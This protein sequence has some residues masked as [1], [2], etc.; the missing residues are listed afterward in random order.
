MRAR[1]SSTSPQLVSSPD[2]KAEWM[3]SMVASCRRNGRD[4]TLASCMPLDGWVLGYDS[5]VEGSYTLTLPVVGAVF[6][7]SISDC[8]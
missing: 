2:L 7:A 8:G 6:L 5:T 3:S 1:Y 4:L